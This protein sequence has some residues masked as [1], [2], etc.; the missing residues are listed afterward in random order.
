M[1]EGL[2]GRNTPVKIPWMES[3]AEQGDEARPVFGQNR[4]SG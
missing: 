2:M 1:R 3:F 4:H